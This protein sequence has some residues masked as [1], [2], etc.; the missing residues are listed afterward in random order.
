MT[1]QALRRWWHHFLHVAPPVADA[2]DTQNLRRIRRLAPLVAALNLVHV[3]VFVPQWIGQPV[4]SPAWRWS[5]ALVLAHVGMGVLMVLV[6]MAAHRWQAQRG[7]W[8][9]R[10]FPGLMAALCLAFC[11][12]LA[13]VDQWITPSITPFLIGCTLV[14]LLLHLRPADAL[15]LYPLAWMGLYWLLGQTQDD[16]R[17]LLSNQ[18]NGLTACMMGCALS[19]L[20]WRNFATIT[21]QHTLLDKVNQELQQKQRELERLTRQDG[22]TG[23]YNRNTFVE[24][25]RQE[26]VRAQ[27][28]GS[29]TAVLL[30]D[31]DHFKRINDSHGHPAGDAVLC[32]VAQLVNS[33]VRSTD[34]VGRLG[35]EEFVVLLAATP[36]AD[37]CRLAEKVRIRL[38]ASPTPWNGGSIANTVSVGVAGGSA[39][40]KRSF[41]NLYEEA[42]QSMYLAKQRGRNQVVCCGHTIGKPATPQEALA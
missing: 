27:R 1:L 41:E 28:Q 35:G 21:A 19:V 18:V 6:A 25:T 36:L 40:Q 37:A 7:T 33:T 16:A 2:A 42:D 15:S 29:Q 11:A 5:R 17:Q 32:H 14:G 12:L 22:L 3:L 20:L 34:L 39:K 8:W 4:G 31:L 26:L 13:A 38:Q 9:R 23:L 30:L 24:L 10:G